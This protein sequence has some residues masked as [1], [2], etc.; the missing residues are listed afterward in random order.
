MGNF[1]RNTQNWN[2]I[3]VQVKSK[4]NNKLSSICSQ[5]SN[6]YIDFICNLYSE[7]DEQILDEKSVFLLSCNEFQEVIHKVS[8]DYYSEVFK[9]CFMNEDNAEVVSIKDFCDD[10]IYS[11]FKLYCDAVLDS[12]KTISFT[13][14]GGKIKELIE[15]FSQTD[16][17]SEMG[18]FDFN[19][20]KSSVHRLK[21]LNKKLCDQHEYMYNM[22]QDEYMSIMVYHLKDYITPVF[23]VIFDDCS[24]DLELLGFDNSHVL[25]L[26]DM[27]S[28]EYTKFSEKFLFFKDNLEFEEI[29]EE[30]ESDS[31]SICNKIEYIDD[32]KRLNKLATD[33]GYSMIR[34]NGDHGIFKNEDGSVVVIPQGRTIGKGLSLK[35]QKVL[36]KAV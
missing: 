17:F 10:V 4:F 13:F 36:L 15:E 16:V 24:S 8:Y 3:R 34:S 6:E 27:L 12:Y 7:L 21:S 23:D 26:I 18:Y 9:E 1:C 5:L 32:Y 19:Y 35:I 20:L 11:I 14:L 31:S 25:S 28:N 2:S 30:C 33:S 22:F 29:L